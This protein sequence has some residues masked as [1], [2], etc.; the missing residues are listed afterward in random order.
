MKSLIGKHRLTIVRDTHP[1]EMKIA[2]PTNQNQ[3]LFHCTVI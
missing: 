1:K 2:T 3:C